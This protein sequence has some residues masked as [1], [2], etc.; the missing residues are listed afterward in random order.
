MIPPPDS[1]SA[2]S[3]TV[4]IPVVAALIFRDARLLIA[5]RPNGKHLAGLW[6]FPGGKL[7]A[8]EDSVTGLVRE[9]QEELAT[10]VEVGRLFEEVIHAYPEK[11]VNLRF[12]LCRWKS[13]EPQNLGCAAIAWVTPAELANYAFPSA[14]A[15]L[16][17]RLLAQPWPIV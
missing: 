11:T 16:L 14:D 15:R 9:L 8:G 12:Y 6:E 1:G 5:R 10:Q 3:L 17:A 4:P 7:E 13:G 2:S